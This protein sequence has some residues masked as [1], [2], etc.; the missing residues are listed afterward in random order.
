MTTEMNEATGQLVAAAV[1]PLYEH[2]VEIEKLTGFEI[3]RAPDL[4]IDADL[5]AA[6]IE[7]ETEIVVVMRTAPAADLTLINAHDLV[8]GPGIVHALARG[9]PLPDVVRVLDLLREE[10]HGLGADPAKDDRRGRDAHLLAL[11]TSIATSL[12][13]VSVALHLGAESDLQSVMLDPP[14]LVILIVTFPVLSRERLKRENLKPHQSSRKNP[15]TGGLNAAAAVAAGDEG[16]LVGGEALVGVE[17]EVEV[18]VG[19]AAGEQVEVPRD[20]LDTE[21]ALFASVL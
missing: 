2:E 13:T 8:S 15:R 11:A 6:A 14:G 21:A 1:D 20:V 5:I 18:V 19:A 3:D 4:A 16:V 10:D 12:P 9:Q 17:V 7:V